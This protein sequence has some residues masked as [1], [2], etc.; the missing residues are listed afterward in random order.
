[1]KKYFILMVV[2]ICAMGVCLAETRLAEGADSDWYMK[3]LTDEAVTTAYP[4]RAF[5][6][7]NGNGVPV[8]VLSTTQ[9]S[10]ISAEDRAVVYVYDQGAPKKVLEVGGQGGDTLYANLDAHTLTH[11]YR[12]SGEE[13]IEV[14]RVENGALALVTKV[15]CY[16]PHHAPDADNAE[17][18]YLQDGAAIT[19]EAAHELCALYATDNA[20]SYE[21][22]P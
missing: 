12:F 17:P 3:I 8:L 18:V 15:D 7:I 4:Y 13:H 10:F 5:V 2:L 14:Y 11:Y 6:D 1:M 22:A 19:E 16:Q 20:I 21:P 9:D